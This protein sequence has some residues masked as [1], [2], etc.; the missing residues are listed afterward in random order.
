MVSDRKEYAFVLIDAFTKYVL[1]HHTVNIDTLSSIAALKHAISLFGAPMRVIADQ[2][3]CFASREFKEYCNSHNINLHLIATGSARANGQVERVMSLLKNMLTAAEASNRSWQEALPDVQLAI[4]CT[5][6]RVTKH[7]PLELL[8]GKVARPS[9]MLLSDATEP[10]VDLDEVRSTAIC[11]IEKNAK[12]DKIR[13]DS[14]KSRPD[15]FVVGDM[16]LLQN[17]ERN[18]AKLDPKYKGPFKVTEVLDGDRYVVKSLN[19]NR[20]Y[21]YARDRMRRMPEGYIPDEFNDNVNERDN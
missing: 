9:E 15:N 3:R 8:I 18:Q 14:T 12:Y 19:C 4:N 1:F 10:V 2:G 7:S 21:K 20:T 11:N 17:E 13:F 16:V 5:K 6:N